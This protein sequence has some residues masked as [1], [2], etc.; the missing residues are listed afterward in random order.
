MA[1]MCDGTWINS[2]INGNDDGTID[3]VEGLPGLISGKH[4]NSQKEI[5]GIC[6]P[7]SVPHVTFVRFESGRAVVYHG[8]IERRTIPVPHSVIVNGR[9]TVVGPGE[10]R[11]AVLADDWT[12][13][14]PT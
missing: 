2:F 9:A 4:N 11:D 1:G 12:A 8:D 13:E 7:G 6:I 3:I 5:F 10:A 14:R